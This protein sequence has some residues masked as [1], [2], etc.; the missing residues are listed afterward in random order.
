MPGP[1][2]NRSAVT[3]SSSGYLPSGPAA[4]RSR[5][6]SPSSSSPPRP[7][8]IR[9]SPPR[10]CTSSKPSPVTI[11]SGPLVPSLLSGPDVPLIIVDR[12]KQVGAALAPPTARPPVA[13]KSRAEPRAA[14]AEHPRGPAIMTPSKSNAIRRARPDPTDG[15]PHCTPVDRH[16]TGRRRDPAADRLRLSR[17]RND[18]VGT[19]VALRGCAVWHPVVRP[20][21]AWMMPTCRTMAWW[22]WLGR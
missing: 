8:Q 15:S 10:P 7:V 1:P 22:R 17:H 21:R 13:N 11:T 12:P 14:S 3:K 9:S 4:S 2:T 16:V 18:S 20:D 19:L 5:P 6:A